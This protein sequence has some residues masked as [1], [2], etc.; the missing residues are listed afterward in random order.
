MGVGGKMLAAIA[1]QD[2]MY[3]GGP[4][5]SCVQLALAALAGGDLIA[6]DNGLLATCAITTLTFADRPEV[7]DAWEVARI[8]AYGRGSLF[9]I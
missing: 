2:W 7:M 9:A 4:S 3:A 6:A 1:A 8:D 5:V